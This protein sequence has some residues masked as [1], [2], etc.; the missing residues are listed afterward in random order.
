MWSSKLD[1]MRD[2][3]YNDESFCSDKTSLLKAYCINED[4]SLTNININYK[5]YFKF[6]EIRDKILPLLEQNVIVEKK[7]C[8]YLGFESYKNTS[9]VAGYKINLSDVLNDTE[10]YPSNYMGT[11][12]VSDNKMTILLSRSAD[13]DYYVSTHYSTYFYDKLFVSFEFEFDN[14][15]VDVLKEILWAN[16][17]N[18]RT[19]CIDGI[20]EDYI[21]NEIQDECMKLKRLYCL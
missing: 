9:N 14:K 7:P 20:V 13:Y 18:I 5:E 11:V 17:Q 6:S 10:H 4:V 12:E 19:E 21:D 8:T 2:V 3:L 16:K 15:N 1:L